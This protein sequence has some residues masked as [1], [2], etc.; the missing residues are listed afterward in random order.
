MKL[1]V[2]LLQ[3]AVATAVVSTSEETN[4]TFISGRTGIDHSSCINNRTGPC[5]SLEYAFLQLKHLG[6]TASPHEF[7]LQGDDHFLNST[8]TIS[9]IDGLTIIGTGETQTTVYCIPPNS[10]T[11]EGSGFKFVSVSNLRIVNLSLEEC[12]TLQLS[13]T[14]R[15]DV[16]A[17]FRSAMYFLNCTHVHLDVCKFHKSRGKALSFYDTSGIISISNSVFTTNIVPE[18][19]RQ[20]LFGGGAILI[21]YTFCTPG[22]QSCN[23]THNTHNR[24]N[25]FMI[26]S[27]LF[28]SN[29]ATDVDVRNTSS[30]LYTVQFPIRSGSDSNYVGQGGAISITFKGNS[31]QNFISIS[32]CTFSNNSALY[33][34]G[35]EPFF[36]DTATGNNITINSCRFIQNTACKRG[37]GA[38][39]LVYVVEDLNLSN[40]TITVH[41]TEFVNNS[42]GWGGAVAVWSRPAIRDLG[43]KVIF[44]NCT[45]LGNSATIGAAVS[46]LSDGKGSHFDSVNAPVIFKHCSFVNNVLTD[47]AEFHEVSQVEIESGILH[48]D[49]FIVELSDHVEFSKNTGSAIFG[50]SARIHI[51]NDTEALFVDNTARHG[52]ALALIGFSTLHVYRNTTVV[53][54]SNSA[55]LGGALY[56]TSPHQTDFILSHKCF[57]SYHSADHPDTWKTSLVFS[58]NTAK[59]GSAIYV[60]SLLPCAKFVGDISTN[61][62]EALRWK[63]FHYVPKFENNTIATSP[64]SVH[65]SLPLE[66]APGEIADISPYS[67]DDLNQ[68]V[69]AVYQASIESDSDNIKVSRYISNGQLQITSGRPNSGFTLTLHTLGARRVSSQ[70]SGTL[71]QCPIGFKLQK[72]KC[73][74]FG[75]NDFVGIPKCRSDILK[76]YLQVGYWAGCVDNDTL[77]TAECPT[78]YCTYPYP[79]LFPLPRSCRDIVSGQGVCTA[80]RRG[81]L[82]GECEEGYTVF[83]HSENF[84]CRRCHGGALGLLAYLAAELLPLCLFFVI[85]ILFQ[86]NLASG[87]G[88]SIAF[89]VQVVLLLSYKPVL[90]NENTSATQ[91]LT[92]AYYFLFGPVN[93]DFFK[94][95]SMS[96]CLWSGATVLDNLAFKYVTTVLG[97]LMLV[98]FI[99]FFRWYSLEEVASKLVCC[100]RAKKRVREHISKT[101]PVVHSIATYLVL[102]YDLFTVTSFQILARTQL[103]GEGEV[104][105]RSVVQLSGDVEYFGRK[106]LQYASPALFAILFLS[107]PPPLILLS[108]PLLWK[109]KAK[110]KWSCSETANAEKTCWLIRKLMPLIDSF[111]GQYRD[112][113]RFFSGLMFVWRIVITAIFAFASSHTYYLLLNAVLIFKLFV[114]GTVAPHQS[115]FNNRMDMFI[116]ANLLAINTLDWFTYT[117]TINY[118]GMQ[119]STIEIVAIVKVFLLYLPIMF[120]VLR[121]LRK[122]CQ[123]LK[124]SKLADIQAMGIGGELFCDEELFDR[125][126]G[127][128]NLSTLYAEDIDIDLPIDYTYLDKYT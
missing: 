4:S 30:S 67:L 21:E 39:E 8:L 51:T 81:W 56:S 100:P 62:N 65:F 84:K 20:H 103:Y 45:W 107:I 59:C 40:N 94:I 88:H 2:T 91:T 60:D 71:G 125:A 83:Y 41:N 72:G 27:C 25:E 93:L 10:V 114:Y 46:V 116:F 33:G 122:L 34:G 15:G 120:A 105:V 86:F 1:L 99:Y 79:R 52:G 31:E 123:R 9:D 14:L 87:I 23:S 127:R 47:A 101:N 28:D 106:H 63:S 69:S 50:N 5:Q 43:N 113:F 85:I 12:G 57:I 97:I 24:N 55:E 17:K 11:D 64:A 102:F 126:D 96:F 119:T 3:L 78:G 73:V 49:D 44:V 22:Q 16:S 38:M 112:N 92:T 48:V 89:F 36:E 108:Y 124:C 109:L 77:V 58:N 80:N 90:Q 7:I 29:K 95:D 128:L 75:N 76:S 66:L 74:C 32:N 18:G 118:S 121:Y 104:G 19:E 117:I 26:D 13:T 110:C 98:A 82:C 53:F 68:N 70:R 35:I 115:R 111:Q 54:E 37:G 6:T 42:G 61:V